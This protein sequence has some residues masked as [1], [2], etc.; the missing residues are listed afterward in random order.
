MTNYEYIEQMG[1]DEMAEFLDKKA[2]C[3]VCGLY[4]NSCGEPH[5]E[6]CTIGIQKWL[7]SEVT[8]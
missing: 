2:G 8:E 7:E 6:K 3:G 5:I 4:D 1:I